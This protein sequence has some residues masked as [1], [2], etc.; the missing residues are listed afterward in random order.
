MNIDEAVIFFQEFLTAVYRQDAANLTVPDDQLNQQIARTESFMYSA[1][2]TSMTSPFMRPRQMTAEE[3]AA[4]AEKAPTPVCRPLYL[5]AQYDVPGWGTCFA[6]DVGGGDET[7]YIAY[8]RQY[9]AME[10][11]GEPKIVAQYGID[12]Y[13]DELAWENIAGLTI[14][15][16]GD[17]VA[18][19]AL[20]APRVPRDRANYERIVASAPQ[21]GT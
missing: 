9:W 3:L 8:S 12:F 20:E 16:T 18:V 2:G 21:G 19:R 6:A 15:P 17:P 13:A 11:D 7:N 5:V 14:G 10:V 4:M 1:P